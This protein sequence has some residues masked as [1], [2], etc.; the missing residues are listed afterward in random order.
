VLQRQ[1]RRERVAASC[2]CPRCRPGPDPLS[3]EISRNC[4]VAAW[5]GMRTL[6]W[7]D[8][9]G[10]ARRY[11]R[12]YSKPLVGSQLISSQLPTSIARFLQYDIV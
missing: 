8:A 5:V 9:G 11:V 12:P 6:S 10:K 4:R 2:Q 3:T 1:Y 7:H